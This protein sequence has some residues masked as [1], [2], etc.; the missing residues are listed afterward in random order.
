MSIPQKTALV[1][2]PVKAMLFVRAGS[3]SVLPET[4][5][6][7]Y[8]PFSTEIQDW[9][10]DALDVVNEMFLNTFPWMLFGTKDA[11]DR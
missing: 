1:P 5:P 2:L 10:V 4:F 8:A 11:V 9:D 7:L 6:I 3:P